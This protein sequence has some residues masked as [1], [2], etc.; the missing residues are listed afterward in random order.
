M[1]YQQ[2]KLNIQNIYLNSMQPVSTK[3]LVFVV[4]HATIANIAQPKVL[5]VITMKSLVVLLQ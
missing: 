3:E 5:F 4:V 2:K 1:L